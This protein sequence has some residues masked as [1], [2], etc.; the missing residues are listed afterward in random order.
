MNLTLKIRFFVKN[1]KK[2]AEISGL[3][4]RPLNNRMSANI[5]LTSGWPTQSTHF[6]LISEL[7]DDNRCCRICHGS[8]GEEKLF[9]YCQ[10][11]GS[12]GLAHSSCLLLWI[13][14]SSSVT[15]EI[16]KENYN[17]ITRRNKIIWKVVLTI[18]VRVLCREAIFDI[19]VDLWCLQW[20]LFRV[21]DLVSF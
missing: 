18:L 14:T 4:P 8:A 21:L 19:L 15:C 10:C 11:K 5:I 9:S 2:Q 20:D 7:S 12:V 1:I 17:I 6:S 13:K 16:C 3:T